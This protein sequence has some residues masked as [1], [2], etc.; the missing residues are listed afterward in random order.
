VREDSEDQVQAS[1]IPLKCKVSQNLIFFRSFLRHQYHEFNS[2]AN[3]GW[4]FPIQNQTQAETPLAYLS[5]M[6]T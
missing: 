3:G 6:L 4:K 5:R 2:L 1:F